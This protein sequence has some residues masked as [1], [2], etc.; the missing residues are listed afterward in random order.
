MLFRSALGLEPVPADVPQRRLRGWA[1]QIGGRELFSWP[2]PAAPELGCTLIDQRALLL[3]WRQRALRLPQLTWLEGVAAVDLLT[4][5]AGAANAS[6]TPGPFPSPARI[7]GV[8]LADG[9]R[10]RAD[11]VVACDGRGSLLRQRAGLA[12][13]TRLETQEVLWF[14]LNGASAAPLAR[15]L[16]GRFVTVVGDGA[17]YALFE[18]AAGGVQLGLL[19]PAGQPLPRQTPAQWRARWAAAAPP[20]LAQLLRHLDASAERGASAR[21]IG[22]AHV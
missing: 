15:W 20:E 17:A 21:E 11:L 8:R 10:L 18:R 16:A 12:C 1:F 2:E 22:R 5:D 14:L 19:H 3:A 13:P 4:G 9:R 7:T 6:P